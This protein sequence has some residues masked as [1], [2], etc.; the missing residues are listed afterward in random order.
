MSQPKTREV[1]LSCLGSMTL[2]AHPYQAEWR[3]ALLQCWLRVGTTSPTLAL[4]GAGTGPPETG[5]IMT[6]ISSTACDCHIHTVT[7][8]QTAH[9][10]WRKSCIL[11]QIDLDHFISPNRKYLGHPAV[12]YLSWNKFSSHLYL[13]YKLDGWKKYPY[14]FNKFLCH[15]ALRHKI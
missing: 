15:P 9:S 14:I 7:S 6:S 13:V 10:Q 4:R 3:W 1:K 11:H 12:A 8:H 2:G 5:L